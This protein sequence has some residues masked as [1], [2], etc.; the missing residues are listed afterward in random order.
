[1]EGLDLLPL[2]NLFQTVSPSSNPELPHP[3]L[4]LAQLHRK[5]PTKSSTSDG[6]Q[7]GEVEW[8]VA[9]GGKGPA[10]L[11]E[12]PMADERKG[13]KRKLPLAAPDEWWEARL[14]GKEV[15]E[16]VTQV[17]GRAIAPEAMVGRIKSRWMEGQ[18][19]VQ[20]CE[21][22]GA[23]AR[24][25]VELIIHITETLPLSLVLTPCDEA[26]LSLLTIL[27]HVI[28]SFLSCTTS[29]TSCEAAIAERDA[30]R[31][32]CEKQERQIQDLKDA[33]ERSRKRARAE[34]QGASQRQNSGSQ[35][36]LGGSSQGSMVDVPSPSKQKVVPGQTHRGALRPGD[37]GYAGSAFRAGRQEDAEF[38]PVSDS[39]SD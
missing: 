22:P 5:P 26:P 16:L 3:L 20:S 30:I 25:G 18:L 19:D 1:M 23:P 27:A 31:R 13:K 36:Q 7:L 28:P 2:H 14:C 12:G 8:I 10:D 32:R 33:S 4:A 11:P 39:D 35:N 17:K 9:L 15:E 24:G 29:R 6:T 21:G 34:G 37:A 38:D